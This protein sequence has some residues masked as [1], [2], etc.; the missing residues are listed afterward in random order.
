MAFTTC[1]L[2]YKLI[3]RCYARVINVCCIAGE[4]VYMCATV[5]R[6]H[7]IILYTAFNIPKWT[8]KSTLTRLS[9]KNANKKKRIHR[10]TTKQNQ[11]KCL[12]LQ[13]SLQN[14]ITVPRAVYALYYQRIIICPVFTDVYYCVFEQHFFRFN[15]TP[16]V[17]SF[18][19]VLFVKLLFLLSCCLALSAGLHSPVFQWTGSILC[20]CSQQ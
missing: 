8:W 3:H 16:F 6:K 10:P 15:S 14:D 18:L 9:N 4:F 20:Y 17:Y 11:T 2:M 7:L 12:L 5:H 1:N 13:K 19:C